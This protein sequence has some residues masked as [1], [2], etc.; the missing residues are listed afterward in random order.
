MMMEDEPL[1]QDDEYYIFSKDRRKYSVEHSSDN[2]PSS[3][4]SYQY[5]NGDEYRKIERNLTQQSMP[6]MKG[7]RSNGILKKYKMYS[8]SDP[9]LGGSRLY[10]GDI[11]YSPRRR[12]KRGQIF[13]FFYIVFYIAYLIAGSKCFQ[14]L[15]V[16]V[17]LDV[18]KDFRH[19]REVFLLEHPE[20]TGKY[21][22]RAFCFL[23]I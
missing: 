17:E 18:R 19:A 10:T 13:L 4:T 22:Q 11:P 20:V 7:S 16:E 23:F 8:E 12:Y 6:N 2:V 3:S 5:V 9:L 1:L 14:K 21:I 15:E